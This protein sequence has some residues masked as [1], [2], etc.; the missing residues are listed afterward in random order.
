MVS[1]ASCVPRASAFCRSLWRVLWRVLS[2]TSRDRLVIAEQMHCSNSGTSVAISMVG[3]GLCGAL[4][5]TGNASARG[6]TQTSAGHEL[7][8]CSHCAVEGWHAM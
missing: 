5:V 3:S 7:I 1:V 4:L 8:Y 2:A 6:A